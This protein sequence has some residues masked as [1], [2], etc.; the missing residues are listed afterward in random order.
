MNK[1]PQKSRKNPK[2]KL[3]VT[4]KPIIPIKITES[5][6][7]KDY[8]FPILFMILIVAANLIC[9]YINNRFL[10]I[11]TNLVFCFLLLSVFLRKIINP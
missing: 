9:Y 8:I 11:S 2:K 3:M 4:K 10:K 1:K 5:R 7:L 6:G